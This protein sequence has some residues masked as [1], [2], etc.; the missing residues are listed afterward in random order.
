MDGPSFQCVN[1]FVRAQFKE[2]FDQHLISLDGEAARSSLDGE[3]QPHACY[4]QAK[5]V[6]ILGI[7]WYI[8]IPKTIK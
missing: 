4:L 6:R 1:I 7:F 3:G 2:M 5:Y 8:L